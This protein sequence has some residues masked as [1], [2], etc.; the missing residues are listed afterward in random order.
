M[1]SQTHGTSDQAG[2]PGFTITPDGA[3]RLG[4]V[5]GETRALRV[6]AEPGGCMGLRYAVTFEELAE[7]SDIGSGTT[8]LTDGSGVRLVVDDGCA[9]LLEGA[10]IDF[11]DGGFSIRNPNARGAC[12]CGATFAA[13]LES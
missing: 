3:R 6:R 9:P 1:T 8:L 13:R 4:A 5:L 10:V 11:G 7:G 2:G 12:A